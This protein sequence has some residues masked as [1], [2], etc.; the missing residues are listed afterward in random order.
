M[1]IVVLHND[2]ATDTAPSDLDVLHQRDAVLAALRALGHHAEA[3]SCTLDLSETKT[4]L[5]AQRPDVVFN[6]VE[7]LSGTD[8]LM[9]AAP[10]LFDALHVPYTGVPT[11]ALL[12][13]NGKLTTKQCL[14]EAGLPTAPW[15]TRRMARWEGL[16][17]PDASGFAADAGGDTTR[18]APLMIKAI[19]EHASF[20]MDDGAIVSPSSNAA[21]AEVLHVREQATG[22]PH[23][24][25][26]FL[27]GREFNLSVLAS[28]AG[29][30]VLPPA[31]IDF[32]DFPP[33][34]P[35]IV[36]YQAKWD[37]ESFEF[38]HTPRRFEFPP[39]D[40]GLLAELSRLAAD[41]WNRFGLRGY[42]R[43]DFRVDRTG[44]P[45]ILEVNSNPCLS[46][47]AGFAAAV[48]R[49]GMTYDQAIDRII[50]DALAH[51][52]DA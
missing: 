26:P 11:R 39:A 48:E 4:R 12:I 27:E 19:W 40:R 34:K 47:D 29:P 14:R 52:D 51:A 46:L 38:H 6:L 25:E 42:A 15:F 43:V 33:D 5:D 36:G 44:R 1:R 3:W 20:H 21:L 23:F 9:A 22:Q 50:Q 8:R 7:S 30:Q 35:R 37:A 28:D 17:W 32:G 24:A 16:P 13:T 41:C 2:V 31:E 45:W 10:L 18:L 49:A